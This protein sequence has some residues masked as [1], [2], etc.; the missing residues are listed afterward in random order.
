[1]YLNGQSTRQQMKQQHEMYVY[2][3]QQFCAHSRVRL[4][5]L[6]LTMCADEMLSY[7]PVA[8]TVLLQESGYDIQL[9]LKL[10]RK[11]SGSVTNILDHHR[12]LDAK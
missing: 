1:M 7:N 10:A 3:T 12:C 5:I 6:L 9:Q 11:L 2:T 4:G 8:Q